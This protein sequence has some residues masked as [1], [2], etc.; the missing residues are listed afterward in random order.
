MATI[1]ISGPIQI[2]EEPSG[3]EITDA[4]KLKR[5]DGVEEKG[6]NLAEYLDGEPLGGA[7]FQLPDD[8]R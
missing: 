6:A 2:C 1:S 7:G 5:F 4:A 3:K 8:V